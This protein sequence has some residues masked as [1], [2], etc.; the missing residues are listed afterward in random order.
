[1]QAKRWLGLWQAHY[2]RPTLL[3]VDC[4]QPPAATLS[5]TAGEALFKLIT[6]DTSRLPV[7]GAQSFS[8]DWT[9]RS[10]SVNFVP[11]DGNGG[12]LLSLELH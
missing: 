6:P 12:E 7:I 11:G 5:I 2:W 3:S 10:V 9:N 4:S 8:C 1:M